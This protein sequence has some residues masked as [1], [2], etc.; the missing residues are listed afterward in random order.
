[1][2]V[3]ILDDHRKHLSGD[4]IASIS[5]VPVTDTDR[6]VLSGVLLVKG[7]KHDYAEVMLFD[8]ETFTED[9][10]HVVASVFIHKQSRGRWAPG[11][12]SSRPELAV[13]VA[14]DAARG[15]RGLLARLRRK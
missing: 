9:P 14:K 2:P 5:E 12:R 3:I 15:E 1:M 11:L 4:D 8:T 7:P 6:P 13:S 10:R